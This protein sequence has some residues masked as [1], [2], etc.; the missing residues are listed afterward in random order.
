MITRAVRAERNKCRCE[1]YVDHTWIRLYDD[2]Q[3]I[4]YIQ[5]MYIRI[6]SPDFVAGKFCS[7]AKR[8][9]GIV[10]SSCYRILI[11]DPLGC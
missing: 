10:P 7:K 5:V 11:Y 2:N 6:I 9:T 3:V 8:A 1:E 4:C